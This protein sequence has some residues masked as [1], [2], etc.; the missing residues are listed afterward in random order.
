MLSKHCLE[1]VTRTVRYANTGYGPQLSVLEIGLSDKVAIVEPNVAFW[2]LIEKDSIHEALAGSLINSLQEQIES[3]K[4]E[5]DYLRFGLKPSAAYFNP[6][7]RCNFNCAY[8]YLPEEMRRKGKTMTEEELC[9]A[10]ELLHQY[11]KDTMSEDIKP[12]IIFHGS[13]PMLAKDQMFAGIKKFRDK[14]HFGVQSNA[15]LL[16]DDA[17]SFMMDYNVG[18]GISLDGPSPDIADSARKNWQ[19]SGAFN[20]V[21]EVLDK[22]VKY[23]AFNVITTVTSANVHTLSEMVDFYHDRGVSVVMFNP[24]RCTQ[25]G[26]MK[27]KPDNYQ[28]SEYF[29]K[30]LD[31]TWELYKK[32]GHK[33]VVANFANVL[34]GIAGPTGRRLM[35]DISPCGGGRCFFAVSANGDVSPC[36]EF[37]GFSEFNGGNLYQEDLHSIL[38]TKPFKDVTD[39]RVENIVPCRNCVIRHY[40]GA[41]CPAEVKMVSGFLNA[42]SPY[43]EFYEEQVRYAFRVIASG[44]EEAYLWDGWK[45]ETEITYKWATI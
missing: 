17:I 6:T 37:I 25:K 41:P 28:M 12:Q 3:F 24:V 8:C 11:F 30:A 4:E 20:K 19:G 31:R 15:T 5:M 14:F 13:E 10:L 9:H 22:L 35:C 1:T 34:A 43:C 42:P 18:I 7:E 29:C 16:D 45:D 36:S 33:L 23:P 32:T 26:G 21:V 27:L 44:R 39:R 38:K 2:A 40:C